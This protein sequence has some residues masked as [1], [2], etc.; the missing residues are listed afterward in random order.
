MSLRRRRLP[1]HLEAPARAFDDLLPP[2]ER[3]RAAL[4]GS[5]P[6]TR[7]PG[8]P[9]AETLSEFEDGLREVRDGMDAWRSADV[10]P[11][12]EACSRGLDEALEFADRV[13]T[14]GVQPEGFEGLIGLI[15]DLLA[16]LDA[17]ERASTRFR[18]LRG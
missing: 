15:G 5:V 13:R 18:E 7:L 16:T 3:A 8:R 6:G 10:E 2:L 1:E 9:L 4:T 17:F 14:E 12:W 11:E